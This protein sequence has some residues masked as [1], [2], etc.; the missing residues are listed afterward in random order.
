MAKG[1]LEG[2]GDGFSNP[3][4]LLVEHGYNPNISLK[5]GFMGESHG[6]GKAMEINS[7]LQVLNVVA[8]TDHMISLQALR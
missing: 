7:E 8:I 6:G 1:N 3:S 4:L 2:G 5:Q